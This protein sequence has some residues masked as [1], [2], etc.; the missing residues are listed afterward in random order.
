MHADTNNSGTISF[1]EMVEVFQKVVPQLPEAQYSI[2]FNK[3]DC[4]KSGYV[5]FMEYPLTEGGE[6]KNILIFIRFL[7]WAEHHNVPISLGKYCS[8]F[9]F[10]TLCASFAFFSTSSPYPSLY[11]SSLLSL[12][13][14]LLLM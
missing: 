13:F 3:I 1:S 10:F 12:S 6:E 11:S 9:S 8:S 5:D 4:N 14:I 7:A 2:E